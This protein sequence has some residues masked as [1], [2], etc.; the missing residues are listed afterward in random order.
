MG[1]G[2]WA[3]RGGFFGQP[4]PEEEQHFL[5]NDREALQSEL[6]VI[7]KKLEEL[8]TQETQEK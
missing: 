3:R 4:N 5:E 8:A 7:N 1:R 2:R 6:N